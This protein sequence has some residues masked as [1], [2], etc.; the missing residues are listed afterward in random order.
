M[1][2][3]K[4]KILIASVIIVLLAILIFFATKV[5]SSDESFEVN[6]ILLKYNVITGGNLSAEV[7]IKNHL[8]TSQVFNLHF[9]G[10]DGIAS[11]DQAQFSLGAKG[12]DTVKIYFK[13]INKEVNVYIGYLVVETSEM[14][15]KIPVILTVEDINPFF[16]IIQ[17]PL[18]KY[19]DVNPGGKI[20]MEIKLFNLKSKESQNLGT[21]YEIKNFDGETLFSEHENI[22]VED[23][24]TISKIINTPDN[25]N[26]GDYV[27]TTS[28]NH[29]GKSISSYFFEIS[30]DKKGER[31]SLGNMEYF[32]LIILLF[33]IGLFWLVLRFFESRDKLILQLQRQQWTELKQNL[34]VIKAYKRELRNIEDI[35]ERRIKLERLEAQKK[36]VIDRIKLKHERQKEELKRCIASRKKLTQEKREKIKNIKEKEIENNMVKK[37]KAWQKQGYGMSELRSNIKSIPN[38]HIISQVEAWKREGYVLK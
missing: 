22:V 9:S 18:P 38:N 33:I 1:K 13:D 6:T 11:L 16:T 21:D 10:L 17:K 25:M 26:E 24:A 29:N 30:K 8:D 27:F 14:T 23:S 28:V 37:L 34:N 31:F 4:R 2:D 20:G 35:S 3:K 7:K 5:N 15:K 12:S 36:M 19:E 32:A